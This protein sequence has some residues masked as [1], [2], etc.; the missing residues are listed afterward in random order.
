MFK[1]ILNK[2]QKVLCKHFHN[3]RG[4]AFSKTVKV[5]QKWLD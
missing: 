4:E 2:S 5:A 1:I 3:N